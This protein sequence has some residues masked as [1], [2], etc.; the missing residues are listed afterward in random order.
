M[1]TATLTP[2][3]TTRPYAQR[4]VFASPAPSG[5]PPLCAA[6]ERRP[7]GGPAPRCLV[8]AARHRARSTL[9]NLT[10]FRLGQLLL[11]GGRPGRVAESWKA[12]FFGS[13]DAA[14]SI[15]VDKPPASL[16]V[17][18]LSVRLFGLQLVRHPAARRR[19]WASPRS[20]V[21]LRDRPA[22]VRRRPPGLL[23]GA[24]PGADAG[25]GADVP[26]QQPGRAARL[27]LMALGRLGDRA[28]RRERRRHEVARARRRPRR[29]R[30]PHQDAP[31]V[32]GRAGVR[33]GVPRSPR[34]RRWGER[35]WHAPRS[36][37]WRDRRVGRVV[38]RDRRA[39][40]GVH[41]AVHR[42]LADQLASS[43]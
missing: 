18:A 21:A 14:N 35:V 16:W 33:A 37:A 3:P 26:V 41:A 8:P 23:A 2:A 27:L 17:M 7:G 36:P 11:L 6:P 12:F 1:D 38:G 19:S 24:R 39:R 42:R 4:V 25:R 22:P 9:W 34:R 30:L 15:T 43:S 31:G 29:L 10:G 5:P 32:P 20:A 40:A 28:G 13:S